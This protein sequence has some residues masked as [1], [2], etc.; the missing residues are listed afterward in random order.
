MFVL[1]VVLTRMTVLFLIF[2][3]KIE[4]VR[5]SCAINRSV[6]CTKCSVFNCT[7]H[8]KNKGSINNRTCHSNNGVSFKIT[9][10]VLF[11]KI[12]ELICINLPAVSGWEVINLTL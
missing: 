2:S 6:K 4:F 9:C 1:N 12:I 5:I 10:K 3:L 7:Y 8:C 11:V